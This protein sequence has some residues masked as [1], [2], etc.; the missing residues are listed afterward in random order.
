MKVNG[1]VNL[2][3]EQCNWHV[4]CIMYITRQKSLLENK[5]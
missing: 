4:N 3:N 5:N 1:F 2:F